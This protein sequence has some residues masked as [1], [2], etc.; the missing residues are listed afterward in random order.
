MLLDFMDKEVSG[1][2]SMAGC[3]S[4]ATLTRTFF[5]FIYAACP[6]RN[7]SGEPRVF[8]ASSS[9]RNAGKD[10]ASCEF[11]S[12]VYFADSDFPNGA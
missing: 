5:K 9:S 12:S 11:L 6:H 7:N 1:V 2:T 10:L 3:T 4:L 8:L